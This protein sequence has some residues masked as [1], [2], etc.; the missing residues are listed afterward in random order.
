MNSCMVL[1]LNV[2]YC[3]EGNGIIVSYFYFGGKNLKDIFNLWWE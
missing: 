1:E 3:L 2:G